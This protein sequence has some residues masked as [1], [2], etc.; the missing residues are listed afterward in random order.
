MNELRQVYKWEDKQW[1]IIDFVKLK[2]EIKEFTAL[3]KIPGIN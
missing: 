2:N 3:F 1:S